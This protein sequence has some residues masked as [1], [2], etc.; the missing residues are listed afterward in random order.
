MESNSAE[1]LRRYALF[2]VISAID[3]DAFWLHQVLKGKDN[4]HM[5]GMIKILGFNLLFKFWLAHL[6]KWSIL[7]SFLFLF[8]QTFTATG[9]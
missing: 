9:F 2:I 3:L 8:R 7:Y 5:T 6:N 1:F 4:S